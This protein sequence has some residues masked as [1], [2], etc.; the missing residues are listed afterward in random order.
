MEENKLSEPVENKIGPENSQDRITQQ[1]IE[2]N[3]QPENLTRAQRKKLKRN[4]FKEE[5]NLEREKKSKKKKIYIISLATIFLVIVSTGIFFIVTK[6]NSE[7]PTSNVIPTGETKEF[8]MTARQFSFSPSKIEVNRGDK[9]KLTITSVDVTHGIAIPKYG[10]NEILPVGRPVTIEFTADK[11]GTF[12]TICSVACGV[13]HSG[14]R[15]RI[16]VK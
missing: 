4:V 8:E 2:E 14:M 11:G 13:G 15:G 5:R 6:N 10:I 1:N 9:V 16:I 12:T 7:I 3:M